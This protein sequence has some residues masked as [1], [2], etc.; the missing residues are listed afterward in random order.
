M[1]SIRSALL[2]AMMLLTGCQS[3][4]GYRMYDLRPGCGILLFEDDL[5][6]KGR[7]RYHTTVLYGNA[8]RLLC[9]VPIHR[10]LCGREVWFTATGQYGEGY[11]H[12]YTRKCLPFHD[13]G[14]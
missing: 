12:H 10:G 5:Q 8:G 2:L 11:R 1:N 4:D 6:V 9:V 14:L 7:C 3:V 13:F